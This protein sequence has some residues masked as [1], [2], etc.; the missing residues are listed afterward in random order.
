MKYPETTLVLEV[1]ADSDVV[2]LLGSRLENA[3]DGC[4]VA[5]IYGI[6]GDD[7]IAEARDRLLT[8]DPI[9]CISAV[10]FLGPF[11]PE[12]IVNDLLRHITTNPKIRDKAL[13]RIKNLTEQQKEILNGNS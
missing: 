8:Q 9:T 12:H 10:N 7:T 6:H 3:R 4:Q 1:M 2:E 5:A 13:L 11:L